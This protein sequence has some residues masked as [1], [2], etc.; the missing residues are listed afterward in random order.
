MYTVCDVAK[1]DVFQTNPTPTFYKWLGNIFMSS[2]V[3][4]ALSSL[5]SPMSGQVVVVDAL[6]I[7]SSM[8]VALEALSRL[9]CL[10]S[11]LVVAVVALSIISTLVQLQ[12]DAV[13]ALF[14][15]SSQSGGRSARSIL[16]IIRPGGGCGCTILQIIFTISMSNI[17]LSGEYGLFL[18]I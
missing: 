10:M 2:L 14:N 7:I 1:T 8:V 18:N 4:E 16:H 3:V 15:T 9:V 12:V 6:S 17:V 13:E 5:V 11:S